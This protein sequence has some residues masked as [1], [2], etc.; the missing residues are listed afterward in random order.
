M[1]EKAFIIDGHIVVWESFEWDE[2]NYFND[3]K[4]L[5]FNAKPPSIPRSTSTN[6]GPRGSSL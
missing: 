3:E 1:R 2:I 6:V 4:F 5:V